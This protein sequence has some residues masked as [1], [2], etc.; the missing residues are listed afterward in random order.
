MAARKSLRGVR[1][2]EPWLSADKVTDSELR[3]LK[4]GCKLKLRVSSAVGTGISKF[5]TPRLESAHYLLH[6]S[7]LQPPPPRNF[8]PSLFPLRMLSVV[9]RRRCCRAAMPAAD[10]ARHL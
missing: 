1:S 8:P 7:S 9:S 10:V 5:V 3:R 6:W 4:Q 2:D